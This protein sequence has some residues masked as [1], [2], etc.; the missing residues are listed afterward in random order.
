VAKFREVAEDGT[1]SGD[2]MVISLAYFVSDVFC[3][4][5]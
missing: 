2:L 1:F 5:E 4:R 3:V